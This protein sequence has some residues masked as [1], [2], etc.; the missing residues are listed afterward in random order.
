MD[1]RTLEGLRRACI[2]KAQDYEAAVKSRWEELEALAK[3]KKVI[4]ETTSGAD[5]IAYLILAT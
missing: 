3:A 5:S 4:S 1:I 2:K